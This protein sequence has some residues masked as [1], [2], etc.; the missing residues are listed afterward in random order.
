MITL[1]GTLRQSGEMTI[2]EK[3]LLKVWVEHT[4]PRDNGTDDLK[5]EELF[6]PRDES[7][8]L[9]EKGQ[10]IAIVVRPYPSGRGVAFQAIRVVPQGRVLPPLPR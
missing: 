9:P 10:E 8:N 3:P 7:K 2:K 1:N 5:I 6:L 4:S